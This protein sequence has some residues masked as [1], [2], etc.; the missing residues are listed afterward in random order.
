[1]GIKTFIPAFRA[2]VG[3][4]KYYIC[5][6]KYAQVA[7]SVNFAHEMGG[8]KDLNSLIQRGISARTGD[9]EEYLLKSPHRF[10]GSLIVACWGGSPEYLEL[11][12]DDPDGYLSGVDSG[13]GVLTFDGSQ[14]YFAL[15]G[16]HRLTA[17]KSAIKQK[18]ELGAEEICVILVSHYDTAQGRER[19]Q[20]LFTNIN[21]NAKQTTKA[22]NI[23]LDVDDAYAVITRRLLT[24]HPFLSENGR[25]RVFSKPPSEGDFTLAAA[26]VPVSDKAAWTTIGVLY[27]VLQRLGHDLPDGLDDEKTRPS[28]DVLETAYERLSSRID[29]LLK[30]CGD[31]VPKLEATN[32]ARTIRAP[33]GKEANGHAFMR[34]VVQLAVARAV[35][36]IIEQGEVDWGSLMKRLEQL[37][38]RIGEGPWL[39]V[40]NPAAGK[41]MTAKENADLLEQLLISHVAP[42][43]KNE[44]KRARDQF[45][46]VIQK[47]YPIAQ[48]LMEKSLTP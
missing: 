34:P 42:R 36:A 6:M 40:F 30:A 38:W 16:Q 2:S 32:D 5:V 26:S 15:D 44:I 28:D 7:N 20:R 33:K 46:A 18:P 29:D 10:L 4:W 43:S 9:I 11:Q 45:K 1:M 22:E 47:S 17:I 35:E 48:E 27:S 39:A 19:T 12:M 21:R 24:E 41:M 14:Q 25:V 37:D 31:V 13:F 23:A 3:D 8:N